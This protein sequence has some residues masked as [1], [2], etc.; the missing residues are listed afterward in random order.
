MA[1]ALLLMGSTPAM[2]LMYF[3]KAG[4]THRVRIG[5]IS[6][7]LSTQKMWFA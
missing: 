7:R 4:P 1:P 6:S 5:L 2:G 3:M